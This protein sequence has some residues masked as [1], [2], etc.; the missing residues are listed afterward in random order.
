MPESEEGRHGSS[1]T[2][3]RSSH[4]SIDASQV[5]DRSP[6]QQRRKELEQLRVQALQ[7]EIEK[8]K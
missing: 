5:D 3:R 6:E 1:L 2:G 4:I 8:L 7:R